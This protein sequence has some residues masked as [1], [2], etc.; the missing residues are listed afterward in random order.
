VHTITLNK[1]ATQHVKTFF[2]WVYQNEI[3]PL[4]T[5]IPDGALVALYAIDGTFL[6]QGYYNSRSQMCVRVLS[7][8]LRPIDSDFFRTRIATALAKRKALAKATNAYR[9]IHSEADFLPGLMV[10]VYDKVLAIQINTLGMESYRT[11]I[12]E[13][14]VALLAPQGIIDKSDAKV[15][16]KEGL[17]TQ[18]GVVYGEV[19][20]DITI[21]EHGISFAVNLHE[22]Q[23]TG[24][25]LDQR[26]NRHTVG[27]YIEAH[28]EVLDIFC[29]A[30]G[31]GLYCLAQGAKVDFVDL[32]AHALEQVALNITRNGFDTNRATIT[33]ADAFT[34]LTQAKTASM[35]YDCVVLDPPPFAKSKRASFGAIKGYKFLFSAGLELA[36]DNGIVALFSCS[37]HVG[38]DTLLSIAKEAS[39]TANV[40][41]E[42]LQTLHAD[43]DHPHILNIPNTAYLS[44]IV[45]RKIALD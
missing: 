38:L 2:G 15:R 26:Y 11:L 3:L 10:D 8:D 29:N 27:G 33:K 24:F 19:T 43:A 20:Q 25:Y 35:R 30:G 7:Y 16:A 31:F 18:N 40:P 42:I 45:V 32:S 44:G 28:M 1:I 22:G 13:A 5:P 39:A 36:K 6:A 14:L 4:K 41:L 12:I 23:K 34:Y 17:Q 9:L 21:H 37:H